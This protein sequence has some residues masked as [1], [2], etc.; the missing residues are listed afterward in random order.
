[1]NLPDFDLTN[2]HVLAVGDVAQ[3]ITPDFNDAKRTFDRLLRECFDSP[4]KWI[5]HD[6]LAGKPV[7]L[8]D[9]R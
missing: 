5:H 1:M 3:T 9:S 4:V 7:L 6:P 8:G 2:M